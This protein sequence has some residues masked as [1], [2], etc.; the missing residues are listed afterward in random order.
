M[1]KL[2]SS[3]L[4]NGAKKLFHITWGGQP[5]ATVSGDSLFLHDRELQRLEDL[6][7]KIV[8]INDERLSNQEFLVYA[9]IKISIEQGQNEHKA[10]Q[11]TATLLQV[12]LAS[13]N[14]FLKISQVEAQFFSSKQQELYRFIMDQIHV[15]QSLEAF[16]AAVQ[17]ELSRILPLLNTEA[18]KTAMQSYFDEINKIAN[19]ELGLELF[20]RFKERDLTDF[21]I[22]KTVADITN[23]INKQNLFKLPTIHSMVIDKFH[24]FEKLGPVLDIKT[25]DNLPE[26]HARILQ[27]MGLQEKYAHSFIK[28][29]ELLLILKEWEKSYTSIVNIRQS[30]DPEKYKIPQEFSKVI[31]GGDIYKKYRSFIPAK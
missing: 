16:K 3:P 21:S 28:F 13:Q 9:K 4:L 20:A 17:E 2:S 7:Q 19:H 25:E 14:S 26:T 23:T 5:K 30:F 24:I 15:E 10:L 29:T 31:A 18:G 27:F 6:H 12:G 11:H 22:L 8:G 1:L